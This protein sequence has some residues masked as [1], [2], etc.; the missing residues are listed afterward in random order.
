VREPFAWRSHRVGRG[1]WALLDLFGTDRDP[2]AWADPETFRPERF[3]HWGGS[4]FDFIPQGGGDYY[5]GHRCPGKWITIELM[6][7]SVR[8]LTTAH[9]LRLAGAKSSRRPVPDADKPGE[10]VRDRECVAEA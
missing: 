6:K 2:R 8:L 3:R 7:Q 1:D 9:A 5:A 4:A 10:P